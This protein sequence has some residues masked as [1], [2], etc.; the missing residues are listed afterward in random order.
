VSQITLP[1]C[2]W[3]Y[4]LA[5]FRF[6]AEAEVYNRIWAQQPAGYR[7]FTKWISRGEI[8]CSSI[9]PSGYVVVLEQR[10]GMRLDRL[11]HALSETERA[12]IQSECLNGIHALRQVDIRLDDPGKHNILY[13]R[14]SRVVTLLDFES[15]QE[16]ESHTYI[17]TYFEMGIIFGSD[18]LL[19][20]PSGG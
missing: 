9:F 17:S 4:L 13:D 8:V 2:Y 5:I 1:A 19:G 3:T 14:E 18:L 12:Y 15:A 10:D 16:L 6:D 20:R 7:S 11:W